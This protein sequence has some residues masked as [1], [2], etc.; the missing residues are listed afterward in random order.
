MSKRL[1]RA[2]VPKEMTWNLADIFPSA[3]LWEQK[4]KA[5]AGEFSQVTQYQGKL[6][7]GKDTVLACFKAMEAVAKQLY[8]VLSYA[9]LKQAEDGTNPDNQTAMGKAGALMAE[10][11]A[12]TS[13]VQS[14]L[15]ALPEDTLKGYLQQP[16]FGD[17]SRELQR[18][19]A[20]RPYMLNPETERVLA[21]LG[22]VLEA[23]ERVY[24]SSKAADMNF[25]DIIDGKGKSHP[26]SFA[27]YEEK[28]ETDPDP[29]LRRNAYK[30]FTQGLKAYQNTYGTTW[31]TEV[32]KNVVLARLRGHESAIHM[33]LHSHE[34][35]M[36]VYTNLHQVIL[37]ELAPHMRK[38]AKL[39]REV[40]G[41]DKL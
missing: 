4:M 17:F 28:Y 35:D 33:I 3:D 5:V 41:L 36:D 16:E 12:A 19:I 20:Q 31:G 24:E 6:D 15:L 40:L 21:S 1:N 18:V 27:L 11:G 7:Q 25:E 30:S 9:F 29:V 2:E 23:P 37:K 13:F 39:R 22:E 26:M 14:E 38:Y 10:F 8:R 32:K 34:V